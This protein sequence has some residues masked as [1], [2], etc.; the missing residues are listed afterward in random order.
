M[1]ACG[2]GTYH[3]RIFAALAA[4]ALLASCGVI[5]RVAQQTVA[6]AIAPVTNSARTISKGLEVTSHNIAASAAIAERTSRQVRMTAAQARAAA[7][8]ADQRRQQMARL[9]DRNAAM[10]KEVAAFEQEPFDI[11][12]AAVLA[13]L[14]EDQAA[15]QRAAQ[16]EAFTAPVGEEIYWEDSGRTGT[17]LT[18]DETPMGSFVC[19]TFIQTVRLDLREERGSAFA[20]RSPDGVWE[21]SLARTELAQ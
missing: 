17:A 13:Q 20:C 18:E 11:L 15:L 6:A 19:R 21:A 4:A 12:P 9:A 1:G 7:R 2:V 16:K 10:R 3:I 5:P 8:A 14:T